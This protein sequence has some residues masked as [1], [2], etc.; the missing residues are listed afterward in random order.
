MM[1]KN[2]TSVNRLILFFTLILSA[3]LNACKKDDVVV[4]P[5]PMIP[6]PPAPPKPDIGFYAL[7]DNNKILQYN[8]K[9]SSAPLASIVLTGLTAGEK[10][11]SIDFRPATGQLYALGSSSRLFLINLNTGNTTVIGSAAFTPAIAGTI[12]NIDFN[13]TVDRVRMVTNTGQ[14]LRLNPETGATAAVDGD[15][16]GGSSPAI[17][18]IAY[19][20]SN[21]G[22]ATTQLFDI[23]MTTKKLYM[24]NPPNA[25]TLVEVGSLGVD[26]TGKPGFDIFNDSIAVAS[27]TVNDTSKLYYVNTTSGKAAYITNLSEKVI[28][29]AVPTAAVAYAISD[30]G[31]FQI[32]NPLKGGALIS[33]T[34]T[35]LA[36]GETIR[37]IDFRPVNGQ[38][39]GI[40]I[41]DA[42][43]AKLVAFNLSTGAATAVGTG[44]SVTAGTNAA[45]FDFNPTVDRIRFVTTT[46]QNLRLNP[47]DG[48]I[49]ATDGN[50]NPGTP[51][52][53]GAAYANSIPGATATV[54]LVIDNGNL[55][56]QDPPNAG[57]LTLIGSLGITADAQS[58]F[59]IGGRTNLAYSLLTVGAVTKL[60][61]I[62]TST[63]TATPVID[64]PNKVTGFSIGS[65]F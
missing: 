61:S 65:G 30:A 14:N 63:G 2:S 34:I 47:N 18:S 19:S 17:T 6:L 60:Y 50:L 10:I 55:Y 39:Y 54:L 3:G 27:L 38:L 4:T 57:T 15:I 62:N 1:I 35:G 48:T 9:I 42:G 32:F 59:D 12:A 37:G 40:A 44:F 29:I 28:D 31:M 7:T 23:D 22:A 8:P 20:N 13:P 16:N 49:A 41:T 21:A 51:A 58:G 11:M 33:K 46:G 52:I 43:T 36:A 56:K 25:G 5:V 24:Q 45:G 64:F 26:F 53:S